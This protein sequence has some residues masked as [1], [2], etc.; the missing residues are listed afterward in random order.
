[1]LGAAPSNLTPSLRTQNAL[2]RQALPELRISASSSAAFSS[3]ESKRPVRL[4]PV[5]PRQG[6]IRRSLLRSRGHSGTGRQLPTRHERDF[7]ERSSPPRKHEMFWHP[8]G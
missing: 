7:A 4:I 5:E 2:S 3:S 8:S 1:M 6:W